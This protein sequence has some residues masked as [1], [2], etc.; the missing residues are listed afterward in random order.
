M[1][2]KN[3]EDRLLL[4]KAENAIELS[5]KRCS[6]VFLGFLNEHESRLLKDSIRYDGLSFCGG[7]KDS[8][9]LM[10]GVNAGTEDFP[11]T[12][13]K[14]TYRK[15]DDLS[16]RDFL[17]ALMGL[18]LNRDVVGD[19]ITGNGFAYVYVKSENAEYILSQIDRIGNC[20]VKVSRE[21]NKVIEY[22]QEFDVFV[23]TLSSLRLDVFV[24]SLCNLSREK[25]N[26]LIRS[27]MVTVNHYVESDNS[28]QIREHDVITIRRYGKYVFEKTLG[29]SKKGKYK[30]EIKKYK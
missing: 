5:E 30:V 13:L 15:T 19:I 16:H 20:G 17:G 23:L 28:V 2:I 3:T 21:D 10:M 29:F 1:N 18:G 22:T 26:N 11:I 27:E 25:S 9:R 12:L 24:S 7:Y 4:R 6:P 8:V 14:F